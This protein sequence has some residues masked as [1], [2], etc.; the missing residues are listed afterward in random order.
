MGC[1]GGLVF[2]DGEDAV[3]KRQFEVKKLIEYILIGG[4]VNSTAV[5]HTHGE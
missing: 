2:P 3:T 1:Y 4:M 5:F